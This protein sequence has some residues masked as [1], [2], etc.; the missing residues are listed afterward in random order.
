MGSILQEDVAGLNVSEPNKIS[1][2]NVGQKLIKLQGEIDK[3]TIHWI[4]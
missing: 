2:K 4:L 1:S 3:F